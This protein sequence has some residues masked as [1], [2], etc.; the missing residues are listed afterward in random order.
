MTH[1][2]E[3]ERLEWQRDGGDA[4]SKMWPDPEAGRQTGKTLI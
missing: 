1:P 4:Q 3:R 2:G